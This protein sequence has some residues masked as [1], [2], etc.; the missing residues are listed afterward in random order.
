VSADRVRIDV[1]IS[2]DR[3]TGLVRAGR[4]TQRATVLFR[5]PAEPEA[6]ATAFASV[7]Q[8]LAGRLAEVLG[9]PIRT[10]QVRVVLLPPLAD[11]RLVPLPPMRP[12]EAEAVIRRDAAR[13][14]LGDAVPRVVGVATSAGRKANAAVLA[15]AAPVALTEAV[16]SACGFLGWTLDSIL[17]AHTAWLGRAARV[18]AGRQKAGVV[19]AADGDVVNVI[20][21]GGSVSSIR[22]LSLTG[23]DLLEATGPGP[24]TAVVFADRGARDA[25]AHTLSAGGWMVAGA[26]TE[27]QSALEAAADGAADSII[28]L[29]PP[30][31]AA[32]RRDRARTNAWLIAAAAIVLIVGAGLV[33]LWGA[34]REL[35]GIRAERQ[36]IRE[37]V[38]PLLQARDSVGR[39]ES[40]ALVI[41]RLEQESPRWTRALFDL[42]LLLPGDTHVTTLRTTGDT[43]VAEATGDRAS[44][45]LQALRRSGSLENI[46]LVGP[47]ERELEDGETT[48]ERFRFSAVLTRL[49]D[50][51]TVPAQAAVLP[52]RSDSHAVARRQ[53]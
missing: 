40:R 53:P 1:A 37:Q 43:L 28:E 2:G 51:Q 47:V 45:A 31:L 24:G 44:A 12:A 39:L 13:Y 20:R 36:A 25:L 11:V 50:P 5:L 22:R 18:T 9:R 33:E 7:F 32:Q 16:R 3:A 30:T 19:I 35:R 6:A 48:T 14:F 26:S 17:P 52:M 46:R 21:S 29:V 10:A 49:V 23:A 41:E 38:A 34:K 8:D 27:S 42:A 4:I 15:A